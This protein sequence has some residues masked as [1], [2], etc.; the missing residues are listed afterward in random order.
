M[1]RLLLGVTLMAAALTAGAQDHK[2]YIGGHLGQAQAKSTCNDFSGPGISCDDKDVMWRILGGY[3]FNRNFAVEAAYSDFGEV[4]AT[5][6]GG[7]ASVKAHALELVGVGI[8]PIADRFSVYGKLGVY[9]ATTDGQVRTVSVRAD[10]SDTAT[11]LTYGF[12]AAYDI[13]RQMTL[14]AEYQKYNDMGGDNVGKDDIDVL[15]VGLLFRF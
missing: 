3:Q 4:K 2:F 13:T 12:G 15:S 14:R 6:P 5:G 11:E 8:L 10:A 7:T 1:K 9:H